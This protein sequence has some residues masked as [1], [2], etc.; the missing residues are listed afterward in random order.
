MDET[1]AA[2]WWATALATNAPTAV[3]LL[4]VWVLSA[5]ERR[6]E[7]L[8]REREQK[9]RQEE[10]AAERAAFLA[11]LSADRSEIAKLAADCHAVQRESNAVLRENA[12]A[13]GVFAS[14]VERVETLLDRWSAPRAADAPDGSPSGG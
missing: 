9:S 11:A 4:V 6:Q 5:K 1:A 10:R 14:V 13:A 8:S 3:A 7:R 12:K 2:P